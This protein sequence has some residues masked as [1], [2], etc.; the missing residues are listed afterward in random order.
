MTMSRSDENATEA[1][2]Y[3]EPRVFPLDPAPSVRELVVRCPVS[4]VRIWNGNEAWLVGDYSDGRELLSDARISGDTERPDYPHQNEAVAKQREFRTFIGMDDPDHS[5]YR[6]MVAFYFRPTRIEELRPTIQD[7]VDRLL[8]DVGE[9][10]QP[11]DLVPAFCLPLPSRV[12]SHM[13]GVPYQDH[14]LFEASAR[15][16]F[17]EGSAEDSRRGN[18]AMGN[19]LRDLLEAKSSAPGD[20]LTSSLAREVDLGRIS[21]VDAVNTLVLLLAAG[22]DTTAHQMALGVLT[23]LEHPAELETFRHDSS[24]LK[25]G[26]DE[27][28]RY[29]NVTHLGRR[30]VAIA[31]IP[32]RGETIHAGDG[33]IVAGDLANRDPLVF[34]DPDRFDIRRRNAAT[35]VAFGS[36][37]HTCL[38]QH[39]ARVELQV[40]L[41]SFFQR[42]PN[43]ALAMPIEELEFLEHAAVYGPRTLPVTM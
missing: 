28:L 42:F 22:H 40:A 34:T 32:L 27:I 35:H 12:I 36:G 16:M 2:F 3:P 19:Y 37:I 24:L 25:N 23:L 39:L 15:A 18:E 17:G 20:D 43:A 8:D 4:R 14:A 41:W 13:L 29:V 10:D 31:D 38:G 6:Q 7:I 9:P 30:R 33:V 5:Y 1:P 11:I 26:V 21:T